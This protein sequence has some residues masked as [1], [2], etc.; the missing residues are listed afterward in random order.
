MAFIKEEERGTK[1][2]LKEKRERA[3]FG[4]SHPLQ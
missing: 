1:E 4:G 2:I 3:D